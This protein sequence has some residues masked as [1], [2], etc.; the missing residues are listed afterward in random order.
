MALEYMNR[1]NEVD[2]TI[3]SLVNT[4]MCKSTSCPCSQSIKDNASMWSDAGMDITTS[5]YKYSSSS[6]YVAFA[7]VYECL[8]NEGTLSQESDEVQYGLQTVNFLETQFGC[9]GFCDTADFFVYLDSAE[10]GPPT[11]ACIYSIA[12]E[13]SSNFTALSAIFIISTIAIFVTFAFS[14]CL[15]LCSKDEE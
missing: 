10:M 1:I 8:I 7:Q 3:N 2:N 9:S 11:T 15:C 14:P 6:D 12:E 4:N 5:S 13:W